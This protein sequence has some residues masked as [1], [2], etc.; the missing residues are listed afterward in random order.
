MNKSKFIKMLLL[1]IIAFIPF[2]MPC[3]EGLSL[4]AWRL[5]GVYFATIVG[6]ILKP[7]NE[8]IMLFI[9]LSMSAIFITLTPN[10]VVQA[11]AVLEGYSDT[12]VWLVFS[13]F[14]LSIAFVHTGLGKRIAYLL[15]DKL[16][17]TTLRMGYVNV[18][19]ELFLAPA[20]PSNTARAGG[21]VTPI[22]N[23]V[24][25]A[26]GS[27]PVES[28]K[29]AGRYLMLNVYM[30]TK[31]TSYLFLT[32]MAPNAMAISLMGPILG[33]DMDYATWFLLASV[34]GLI[35]LF[36]TPL[37]LY[38][39]IKPELKKVNNKE[40]ARKGLQEL[41]PIKNSEKILLV[42][43]F[44]ALICWVF[45]GMLPYK[46]S[47]WIVA[48]SAMTSLLVVSVIDWEIFVK[49][50][51]AWATLMWYGG[52]IGL[53]KVLEKANFFQWLASSLESMLKGVDF[54]GPYLALAFILICT[55]LIRY[56]FASGSAYVVA[57]VPVFAI[58]GKFI[59]A[60]VELLFI[61]ILFSNAYGGMLTHYTG[62]PGPIVFACGYNDIPSWWKAGF[63]L[64]VCSL[65]V[66]LTIGVLWW[67]F[68]ISNAL[69]FGH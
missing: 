69:L 25:V 23:S 33:L 1:G 32:A 63:I 10:Q 44:L 19:L 53:A 29:K 41:G 34:P 11:K 47:A 67:K 31:T 27:D 4:V 59:G 7:Y 28:P 24:S 8:S 13:A 30:I 43:F 49:N 16:G 18:F 42:I 5:L 26:L 46:L 40:I 52:I 38:F 51:G 37:I 62:G 61:G 36:L 21:I 35:C 3:P 15:I 66:H 22:M 60:P 55:C 64:V 39:I 57:M 50:K 20:T 14:S 54:G 48:I 56:V 12:S 2:F 6:L 45:G 58:V 9:S 65:V 17:S 68:L